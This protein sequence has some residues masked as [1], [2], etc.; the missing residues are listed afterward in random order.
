MPP[1]GKRPALVWRS[2][3]YSSRYASRLAPSLARARAAGATILIEIADAEFQDALREAAVKAG[4]LCASYTIPERARR[5]IPAWLAGVFDACGGAGSWPRYPYGSDFTPVEDTLITALKRFA[6][7][8]KPQLA[9]AL[10]KGLATHARDRRAAVDYLERMELAR[11]SGA[12]ERLLARVVT[13]A[14][15]DAGHLGAS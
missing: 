3:K 14:L 8:S 13:A 6:G 12:K 5:N 2:F 9:G 1:G 4:K 11:P 15:R 10:V 7:R